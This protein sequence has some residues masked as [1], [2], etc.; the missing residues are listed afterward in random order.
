MMMSPVY[1]GLLPQRVEIESVTGFESSMR[2]AKGF[3]SEGCADNG[4][5]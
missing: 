1:Q 4:G 5:R 2:M 3:G